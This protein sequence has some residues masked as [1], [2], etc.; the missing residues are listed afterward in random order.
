MTGEFCTLPDLCDGFG[1]CS[2]IPATSLH[3]I[4]KITLKYNNSCALM[5]AGS[6][7]CWGDNSEGQL[8]DGTTAF[9]N[10]PQDVP[11][12]S[13]GV[14]SVA[15]GYEFTCALMDSGG[16]KCS[17][18]NDNGQLGDNTTTDRWTHVDA[19][20][21]PDGIAQLC[22][23]GKHTCVLLDSG[24]I[25]CWGD[26]EYGQ[27]GN[28]TTTDS[29]TPVGVTGLSS[30][31]TDISCGYGHTCALRSTGEVRCWGMNDRGEL[32]D[33]STINRSSPVTP[34]GLSSGVV[35]MA[36]GG[37]HACAVLDSGPL[38][39]WGWNTHGQVGDGT[40]DSPKTTPVDVSGLSSGVSEVAGSDYNTCAR[41]GSTRR[42]MCWGKNTNGALGEQHNG[43]QLN[44]RGSPRGRGGGAL[45][46]SV[47][48]QH[49]CADLGVGLKCWGLNWYGDIGDGTTTNAL[50]PVYVR[51]E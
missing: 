50:T 24:G 4:D 27:L 39:C 14:A 18:R 20:V 10:V 26:N 46:M 1:E 31:V 49:G 48:N 44:A 43:G 33:G 19:T 7:K 29:L 8:G 2:G 11:G 17:G 28:G 9:S 3:D 16:V 40:T 30:G 23:G 38:K 45:A 37:E 51:C 42:V 35:Y 41:L 36:A 15:V 25:Q 13:A 22:C 47:G 21:A 6:V 34:S 12:L 5:N 32:G